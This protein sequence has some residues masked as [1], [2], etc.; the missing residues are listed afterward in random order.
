[1][2]NGM[3]DNPM[4][5]QQPPMEQPMQT[6]MANDAVLDMHLTDDVKQALQ[7]K[8]VDI[9]AV[10]DRGPKEP[11]VVIPV[12]IIMQRYPGDS[13]ES[14]MREFVTDMTKTTQPVSA[15]PEMATAE[16]PQSEGL[17]A[18]MNRP[19]MTA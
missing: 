11:V 10:A 1:M 15:Q 17:G 19:P 3:M 12:S 13:P 5:A 6:G 7:A 18:P 2:A 4:G 8:G 14:S 9:S 16:A